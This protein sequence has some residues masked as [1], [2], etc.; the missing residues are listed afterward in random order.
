MFSRYPHQIV[1]SIAQ[2]ARGSKAPMG[3]LQVVFCGDFYQLPPVSQSSHGGSG[4]GDGAGKVVQSGVSTA[5]GS[6]RF[7]FQSPLWD[8]LIQD[9][10]D[11]QQVYRQ[12]GDG[13]FIAVLNAVRAGIFSEQC[14]QVLDACVGR[15]LD[16]GDG[17]LPT[18][19]F[20]HK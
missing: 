3:G 12:S 9:S 19:I 7:C 16:C 6:S 1:S 17:I 20:T 4:S 5:G 11:L 2:R 8:A 18:Q 10:F 14:R 13:D 15:T